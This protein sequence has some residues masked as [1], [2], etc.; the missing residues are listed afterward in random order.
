MDISWAFFWSVV[1][2]FSIISLGFILKCK[3]KI[4]DADCFDFDGE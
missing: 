2:V 4:S 3:G 1:V